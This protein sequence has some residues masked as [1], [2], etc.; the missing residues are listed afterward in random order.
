MQADEDLT[1]ELKTLFA[2]FPRWI[3]LIVEEYLG[4]SLIE[5]S[6]KP[7]LKWNIFLAT[8]IISDQ[9][10]LYLCCPSNH[11]LHVCN[12]EGQ[13][14]P[15]NSPRFD[16]PSDIDFYQRRFYIIH[17]QKVSIFDLQFYLLSSFP[18][19][20]G[21]L[22]AKENHLKVDQTYIYVTIEFKHQVYTYTRDGKL[23]HAIGSISSSPKQGEFNEPRGLTVD[24][25]TLY[26]CDRLN[27]R[28]QA[29]VKNNY[30]FRKQWGSWGTDN[31]QF[32]RPYSICFCQDILYVGDDYSVQLFT[33]EGTFLQRIGDKKKRKWRRTVFFFLG[34]CV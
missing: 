24:S 3:A 15:T 26:I 16:S 18:V 1:F 19:L 11:W 20:P 5:Y 33:C 34:E 8:G 7:T 27:G 4:F 25:N 13:I 12:L 29:L 17:K 10:L 21:P 6:T 9:Q 30:F 14:V 22:F 31:G 28:I 23:Q 32:I 2:R